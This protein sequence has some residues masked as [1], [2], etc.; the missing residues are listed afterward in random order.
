MRPEKQEVWGLEEGDEEEEEEEA[1]ACGI[2]I[3]ELDVPQVI[4]AQA[5][6]ILGV[7]E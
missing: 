7:G 1:D 6:F 4:H 3:Q 2:V 5:L